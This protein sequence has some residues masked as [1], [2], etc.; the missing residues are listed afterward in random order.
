MRY[1]AALLLFYSASAV[2]EAWEINAW[3]PGEFGMPCI[4]ATDRRELAGAGG[5]CEEP[6]LTEPKWGK[7]KKP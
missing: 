2:P 1:L 4:T 6:V 7:R 3:W 5:G